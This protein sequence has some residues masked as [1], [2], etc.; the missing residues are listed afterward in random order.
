M[1]A[2][3]ECDQCSRMV[4]NLHDRTHPRLSRLRYVVQLLILARAAFPNSACC[5]LKSCKTLVRS[6]HMRHALQS[7]L[8]KPLLQNSRTT[9]VHSPRMPIESLR[10]VT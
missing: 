3:P 10:R 2:T 9:A 4:V 8:D 1:L 7:F 6:W 5:T